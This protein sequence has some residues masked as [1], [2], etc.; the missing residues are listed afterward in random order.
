MSRPRGVMEKPSAEDSLGVCSREKVILARDLHAIEPAILGLPGQ[1]S[2]RHFSTEIWLLG[3]RQTLPCCRPAVRSW[4]V[5]PLDIFA[6]WGIDFFVPGGRRLAYH[7]PAITAGPCVQA[8]AGVNTRCI[9]ACRLHGE[10]ARGSPHSS[11]NPLT[12]LETDA[13]MW[14][15][16]IAMLQQALAN[17]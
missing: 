2:R 17:E 9:P 13:R 5:C 12:R 15:N 8:T 11:K 10:T 6:V 4:T 7:S 3:R 14:G 16:I 1:N